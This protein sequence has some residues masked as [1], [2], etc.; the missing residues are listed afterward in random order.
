[1]FKV[2]M[3]QLN[4]FLVFNDTIVFQTSLKRTNKILGMEKLRKYFAWIN[5]SAGNR[6]Y[7]HYTILKGVS[8]YVCEWLHSVLYLQS[9]PA[10]CFFLNQGCVCMYAVFQYFY[11]VCSMS[12]K[13]AFWVCVYICGCI[14]VCLSALC[15]QGWDDLFHFICQL[16]LLGLFIL[17]QCLDDLKHTCRNTQTVRH[18]HEGHH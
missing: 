16:L 9:S 13:S 17:L 18:G 14:S 5:R 15:G 4:W 6:W 10:F 12:I 8:S 1:M 3:H 7:Q 2:A 11:F